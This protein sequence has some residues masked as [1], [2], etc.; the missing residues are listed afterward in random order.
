MYAAY[1]EFQICC[2][3]AY[4]HLNMAAPNVVVHPPGGA[5][6]RLEYLVEIHVPLCPHC[7]LKHVRMTH[8]EY[9]MSFSMMPFLCHHRGE[10]AW[11]ALADRPAELVTLPSPLVRVTP[12]YGSLSSGGSITLE[13]LNA[14][15][16]RINARARVCA[17]QLR[18]LENEGRN[19]DM[20][21][22]PELDR[23]QILRLIALLDAELEEC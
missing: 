6:A 22:F 4:R 13:K 11:M 17:E 14:D 7:N 16:R 23:Q 2:N 9:V 15:V 8:R 12:G 10:V 19:Y 21:Y 1:K 3:K 18:R 5:V 20:R